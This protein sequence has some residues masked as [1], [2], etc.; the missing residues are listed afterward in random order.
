M[1]DK[2]DGL[3]KY[4]EGHEIS[5]ENAIKLQNSI[6][7]KGFKDAFVVA[8]KGSSRITIKEAREL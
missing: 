5:L 8:Y 3:Y 2:V 1:A 7:E 4:M 6:R